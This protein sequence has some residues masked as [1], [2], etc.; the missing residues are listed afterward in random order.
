MDAMNQLSPFGKY[1]VAD[2]LP[3]IDVKQARDQDILFGRGKHLVK[4]PGNEHL[5]QLVDMVKEAYFVW[6]GT[7]KE[8]V[9]TDILDT[10]KKED[11]RFLELE[12]YQEGVNVFYWTKVADSRARNKVTQPQRLRL[13]RSHHHS[14]RLR[15][16]S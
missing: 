15:L 16:D 1:Q 12:Q 10:M 6:K 3:D 13:R 5:A 11:R 8:Q 2:R 4:H 9:V 7:K 14:Y